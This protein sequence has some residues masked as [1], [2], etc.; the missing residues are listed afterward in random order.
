MRAERNRVITV[1]S[2]KRN[3]YNLGGYTIK[4]T[5]EVSSLLQSVEVFGG[6]LSN[7]VNKFVLL[8]LGTK[9]KTRLFCFGSY[10]F[11]GSLSIKFL[12]MLGTF[13]GVPGGVSALCGGVKT[14]CLIV[15]DLVSTFR[16]GTRAS[17]FFDIGVPCGDIGGVLE[18]SDVELCATA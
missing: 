15:G 9:G 5:Y 10:S 6:A 7:W 11:R 17:F 2:E 13:L 18:A 4:T 3:T 16:V 1:I 12:L 8:L 14:H